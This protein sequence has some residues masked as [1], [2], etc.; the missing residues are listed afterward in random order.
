M[1]LWRKKP[2][3]GAGSATPPRTFETSAELNTLKK[4]IEETDDW[5]YKKRYVNKYEL[6]FTLQNDM[7]VPQ[8]LSILKPLSRSY[9]KMIEMLQLTDFYQ[10]F[11]SVQ[12]FKT[13]HVAEGPGGFIEAFVDETERNRKAVKACWAMTLKPQQIHVPGWKRA[14][15]FLQKH[16]FIK[17][18]YGADGTGDIY[19]SENRESLIHTCRAGAH[20]FTADGG[21]DFTDNFENQEDL[22]YELLVS[23]AKIGLRVLL[24]G[25]MFVLKIFD[26]YK[27]QTHAL[28]YTI[29]GC[30]KEWTIYKPLMS[31]PCNSERYFIG[32]GFLGWS[33][34]FVGSEN[35]PEA[36]L[37]ELEMFQRDF[38]LGQ[39]QS[40]RGAFEISDGKDWTKHKVTAMEWCQKFH[41]P[42]LG[43][44]SI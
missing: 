40:L 17:I 14:H 3:V 36:F 29:A 43:R 7:R 37:K 5:D 21:F 22:V 8:S 2:P 6:V 39:I 1:I 44:L 11:T 32:K 30:F 9:F 12:Q 38:D 33:G 18:E 19:V 24:K 35:V 27:P 31:R 34:R 42:Y 28:L 15:N 20:L 4:K 13:C 26:F 16:P 41:I 10:Q 25:G 23:S